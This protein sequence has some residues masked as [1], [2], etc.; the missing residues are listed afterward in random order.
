MLSLL[1]LCIQ[2]TGINISVTPVFS[3]SEWNTI[4]TLVLTKVKPDST[5]IFSSN[6]NAISLGK[7]L[8]FEKK[9]SSSGNI[10]CATCHKSDLYFTDGEKVASGI[11]PLTRNT[12]T[13]LNV[14]QQRWF[15]WDG[16]ADV[17]WGQPIETLENPAE[18][19]SNRLHI[20]HTINNQPLLKEKWELAFGLFPN[21][22]NLPMHGKPDG[23]LDEIDAWNSLSTKEKNIINNI[24]AK[25]AKAIAAYISSLKTINAPFDQFVNGNQNAISDSAKRGLKLFVGAAGCIRCHFG[26][27]L[28]DDA[29]HTTGVPP[30]NG[31]P[32]KDPGRFAAI[33]LLKNAEFSAN[34]THSDDSSGMRAKITQHIV[35][36]REDW[37]TFRT[38]SLRNVDKTPPYMHAGQL[39]ALEDVLEHYSTLENF[40]SVDHHRETILEPLNLTEAEKADL[41]A[42]LKSLTSPMP[43]DAT[44]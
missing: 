35:K 13:I 25:T 21:I 24:S 10:S 12:P 4:K 3:N 37:G 15:F 7:N 11:K 42:F 14:A 38:P 23:T 16:R 9:F 1:C 32:L 17:L 39:D 44:E 6:P 20:A 18:M 29:F 43:M 8:F 26:P 40:I 27:L 2:L 31:G 28:T 36:R 19:N 22:S 5:N 33:D 30:L 34:S 41:I